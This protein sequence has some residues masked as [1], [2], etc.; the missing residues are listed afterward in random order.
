MTFIV[1]MT[2]TVTFYLTFHENEPMIDIYFAEVIDYFL[3][4]TDSIE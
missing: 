1:F 4:D 2:I 3:C